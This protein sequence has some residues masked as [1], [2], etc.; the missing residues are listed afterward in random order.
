VSSRSSDGC[1]ELDRSHVGIINHSHRRHT[2]YTH[3]LHTD[4][5]HNVS[6]LLGGEP[7]I[8][9]AFPFH[10]VIDTITE[11]SRRLSLHLFQMTPSVR[12]SKL[13][14]TNKGASLEVSS[15]PNIFPFWGSVQIQISVAI[16]SRGHIL[17][18]FFINVYRGQLQHNEEEIKLC[19]LTFVTTSSDEATL[20]GWHENA[21]IVSEESSP[22]QMNVLCCRDDGCGSR[23]L[24]PCQTPVGRFAPLMSEEVC[25][26][27]TS[28]NT[29]LTSNTPVP[30]PI[31]RP[32]NSNCVHV[33]TMHGL[34][35]RH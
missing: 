8:E 4:Y 16:V 25:E 28:T 10:G 3:R 33:S 31:P 34:P 18:L 13:Q 7:F 14:Q 9:F 15:S 27:L 26:S 1:E 32:L 23:A 5:T 30:R 17:F 11:R 6:P 29:R 20:D 2:D 22:P 24:P 12:L 21:C 35:H 19:F